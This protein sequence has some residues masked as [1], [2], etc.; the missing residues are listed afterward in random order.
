MMVPTP[1]EFEAEVLRILR[2]IA[3]GP[4]RDD[5]DLRVIAESVAQQA[6]SMVT[7][8]VA[9]ERERAT[10]G[11]RGPIMWLIG[12]Q[13]GM[14]K[15]WANQPDWDR[16]QANLGKACAELAALLPENQGGRP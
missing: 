13:D 1:A 3:T 15:V 5:D 2:L 12:L 9:A 8:A 11:F 16:L 7:A 14:H 4:S 10:T 6:W